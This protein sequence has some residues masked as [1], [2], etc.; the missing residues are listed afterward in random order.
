V[1]VLTVSIGRRHL[2]RKA[3]SLVE[4]PTMAI[5]SSAFRRRT[6]SASALVAPPVMMSV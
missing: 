3:V 2:P 4:V 5:S 1:S 6:G